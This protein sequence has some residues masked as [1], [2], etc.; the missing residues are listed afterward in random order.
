MYHHYQHKNVK[1]L[2]LSDMDVQY[3]SSP[4]N[5]TLCPVDTLNQYLTYSTIDV[6]AISLVNTRLIENV[7]DPYTN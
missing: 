7:W 6:F 2:T 4:I 1:K 5:T 3:F